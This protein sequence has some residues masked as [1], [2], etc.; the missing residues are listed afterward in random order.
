MNRAV[1]A[2]TRLDRMDISKITPLVDSWLAKGVNLPLAGPFV[3]HCPE[4]VEQW[5]ELLTS[6]PA[7]A[8][9]SGV[10]SMSSVY[11]RALLANTYKP[12]VMGR[13]MGTREFMSQMLGK[14][15]RWETLGIFFAAASRAAYDTPQF[16]PLYSTN[17]QRHRLIKDLTYIGDC[18]LETCLGLDCLNDLQLVLQYENFIV[19]SQVDGDQSECLFL[20]TCGIRSRSIWL[21]LRSRLSLLEKNRRRGQLLVC[22]GLS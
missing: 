8:D 12:I 16:A 13:D 14:N 11:V 5:R 21:T 4:S 2:L 1:H 10:G 17:E 20:H 15:L 22:S 9:D 3:A 19:H 18:C 7:E 6:D